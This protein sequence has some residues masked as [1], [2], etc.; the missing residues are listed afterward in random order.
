[1]NTTKPIVSGIGSFEGQVVSGILKKSGFPPADTGLHY[2]AGRMFTEKPR[3]DRYMN[4]MTI[5]WQPKWT[6]GLFLGFSRLFY[7]YRQ[8]QE[9]GL[10]GY[11]PILGHW[12]K[13]SVSEAQDEDSR[14]RDQ[15]FSFYL[16]LLLPKEQAEFY[17][18]YGR[19]D[20][21]GNTRDMA[22]EPE[23]SSASIVGF[24]KIFS[25]G[26]KQK[27]ELM[28]EFTTLQI[29]STNFVREQQSWY[30]HYQ[31]LDGYT[32]RGQVIGAGIG[33]G[34]SNQTV[35]LNWLKEGG[36]KT[37]FMLERVVHNNDYYY[38]A[39][40]MSRDYW[41]HWVDLSLNI[42]KSWRHKHLLFDAQ[43]ILVSTLNFQWQTGNDIK[44]VY[45]RFSAS[46]IF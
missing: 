29:P 15:L 46:Y 31:V 11:L 28:A 41:S 19:N 39:F 26:K 8:D 40:S 17:I 6:K 12:F 25:S 7:V 10:N 2:N 20:H 4:G 27:F 35:G 1:L 30:T 16:R 23:H 22:L 42:S 9:P 38:A 18:E 21:A 13:G 5:A 3:G 34:G 24:K 14:K 44:S 33:P 43:L 45:P 32:H 36:T 37:G